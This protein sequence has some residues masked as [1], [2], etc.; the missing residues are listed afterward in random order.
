M[1]GQENRLSDLIRKLVAEGENEWVEFKQNN[2]N[3]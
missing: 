1:I 3:L 2:H